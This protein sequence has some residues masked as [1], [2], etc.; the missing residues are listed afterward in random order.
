MLQ[1]LY[2]EVVRS[3]KAARKNTGLVV[4]DRIELYVHAED[5]KLL[6]YL[7]KMKK[8]LGQHVGAKTIN[9]AAEV[10]E[11]DAS[12]QVEETLVAIRFTKV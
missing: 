2:R 10:V 1:S 3:I 4:L 9:F 5:E 12:V 8:E 11:N 6:S 7:K